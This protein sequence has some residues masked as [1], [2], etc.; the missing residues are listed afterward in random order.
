[1]TAPDTWARSWTHFR[2]DR[3]SPGYCRVTFEHPPI[4]TITATT[5]LEL[6]EQARLN[7]AVDL[8]WVP[9]IAA[10]VLRRLHR[11]GLLGR[12]VFIVGTN[13]IYAYEAAAGVFVERDL[14]AQ[15]DKLCLIAVD[16][17]ARPSYLAVLLKGIASVMAG[18]AS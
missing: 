15:K 12:N 10:H 5:V 11:E 3:R 14:L 17:R 6:S 2:I 16:P 18:T 8:G 4:N 13:A 7:K 1:M 9:V